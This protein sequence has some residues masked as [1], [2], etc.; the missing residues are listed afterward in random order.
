MNVYYKNNHSRN[1]N[2]MYLT[3]RISYM[4]IYI[5]FVCDVHNIILCRYDM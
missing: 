1:K 3:R 2:M 5:N 4:A